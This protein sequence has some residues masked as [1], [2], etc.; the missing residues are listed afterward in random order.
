MLVNVPIS[1]TFYRL[2]LSIPI[3]WA[4]QNINILHNYFTKT[5]K[6]SSTLL[7]LS[8][9][10][11]FPYVCFKLGSHYWLLGCMQWR[12]D[13]W[14]KHPRHTHQMLWEDCSKVLSLLTATPFAIFAAYLQGIWAMEGLSSRTTCFLS[15]SDSSMVLLTMI[16]GARLSKL[17]ASQ[18][19]S[20][21]RSWI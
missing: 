4:F 12:E 10:F 17:R 2:T 18:S 7:V 6:D 8:L 11:K 9:K 20:E 21:N 13:V 16:E 1:F 3:Y 14:E 15:S 19:S 5:S